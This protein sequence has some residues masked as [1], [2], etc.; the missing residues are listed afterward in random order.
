MSSVKSRIVLA[1][2][3]V[4]GLLAQHL[5][6]TVSCVVRGQHNVTKRPIVM[7]GLEYWANDQ[8]AVKQ[9]MLMTACAKKDPNIVWLV[10]YN[11]LSRVVVTRDQCD[12]AVQ[13]EILPHYEHAYFPHIRASV[14]GM[15]GLL[16]QHSAARIAGSDF[17]NHAIQ[18]YAKPTQSQL[19]Q[20]CPLDLFLDVVRSRNIIPI[21]N[22]NAYCPLS[23]AFNAILAYPSLTL[24]E[25]FPLVGLR[26]ESYCRSMQDLVNESY[27]FYNQAVADHGEMVKHNRLLAKYFG[28]KLRSWKG[29]IAHF[30]E[31]I[32]V[33]AQEIRDQAGN[34]SLMNL[35]LSVFLDRWTKHLHATARLEQDESIADRVIEEISWI[36][37]LCSD[38]FAQQLQ[39]N[40]LKYVLKKAYDLRANLEIPIFV[41]AGEEHVIELGKMLEKVGYSFEQDDSDDDEDGTSYAR[42]TADLEAVFREVV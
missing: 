39:L 1:V 31:V 40:L 36:E 30:K 20:V 28:E 21:D 29:D 12:K 14:N 27:R 35:P 18:N 2:M 7:L 8:E 34:D 9:A 6:A 23:I 4:G 32:C 26:R 42:A 16:I 24:A 5:Y 17:V 38:I 3:L 22:R 37:Q 10:E 19:G 15:A 11:P 33:T 13:Q 25:L 41:V